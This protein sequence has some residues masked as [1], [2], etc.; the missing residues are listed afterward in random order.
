MRTVCVTAI[1]AVLLLSGVVVWMHVST[2]SG[3][4]GM[5]AGS[6]YV[7]IHNGTT[8]IYQEEALGQ[9]DFEQR[10]DGSEV[11]SWTS[12]SGERV[13]YVLQPGDVLITEPAQQ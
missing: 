3:A 11:I 7:D 10:R 9:P 6:W 12:V 13:S 8:I 2:D 4:A 1:T 5:A